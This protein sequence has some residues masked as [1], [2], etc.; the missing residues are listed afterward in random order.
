MLDG[1][2]KYSL[3]KGNKSAGITLSYT[4]K[5]EFTLTGIVMHKKKDELVIENRFEASSW[6][7]VLPSEKLPIY[8]SIDGKGV[9]H[10]KLAIS[11]HTNNQELLHQLLPNA[12]LDDFYLQR[13]IISEHQCW[14]SVIRKNLLDEVVEAV[15]TN[16]LFLVS[17]CLG[18]FNLEHCL[19]VIPS[20]QIDTHATSL[21]IVNE[22]ITDMQ[23]LKEKKHTHYMID[24]EKI[25]S[26]EI[27]AFSN[28][29]RH[30]FHHNDA[31]DV[32][33]EEINFLRQEYFNKNKFTVVGFALLILFFVLAITNMLVYNNYQN[34]NNQLQYELNTQQQHHN[35]L[36]QLK[37]ELNTKKQFIQNSGLTQANKIAY[38]ADQ[39]AMT[40]PTSIRLN[41]L[42][43]NPLHKKISKVEDINFEYKTIMVAG[44]V[45]K[46]IALNDWIKELKNYEW[47]KSIQIISF[48]QEN[49][50]TSGQFEI[51]IN[52][53]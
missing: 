42:T 22:K 48:V 3:I 53:N 25:S 16:N 26:T 2:H 10:K 39:I 12:S 27:V 19:T 11:E 50:R 49:L 30:Y 4:S 7:A 38:Y 13:S 40:I 1:L 8:L 17:V 14:V 52:I 24:Q 36:K 20:V 47:I 23:L 41:E 43:I 44:S 32:S 29:F 18:P 35:T 31:A 15:S 33:N 34:N 9:L 46:S 28:A 51:A 45:N 5:Q 6:N 21:T 37:E